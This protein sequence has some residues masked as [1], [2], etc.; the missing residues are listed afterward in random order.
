[1]LTDKVKLV[2]SIDFKLLD[3]YGNLI[4]RIHKD[5]LVVT[6]GLALLL[7]RL[8]G[9]GNALTHMGI[10]SGTTAPTLANTDLE[11]SV[12]RRVFDT[13]GGSL[14]GTSITFYCLF[15]AGTGTGTITEA[16][17]FNAVSGGTMFSRIVFDPITKSASLS[18]AAS[19]TITALGA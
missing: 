3:K 19:W 5:N 14:S 12:V 17:L 10:G 1:M 2:G 15:P 11:T 8:G 16:G 7:S 18:L 4:Q 6:T 9:S 13:P